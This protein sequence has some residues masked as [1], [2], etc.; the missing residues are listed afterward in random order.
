[1]KP[2]G[3]STSYGYG[4]TA[5]DEG[6]LYR[7]RVPWNMWGPP[8]LAPRWWERVAAEP[9]IPEWD[10]DIEYWPPA[11]VTLD[12]QTYDLIHT[13]AERGWRPDD[14]AMHAVWKLRS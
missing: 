5:T 11:T 1:M 8:S 2:T 6:V 14:P 4:M 10:P 7:S 9:T 13:H 3:P 12:G